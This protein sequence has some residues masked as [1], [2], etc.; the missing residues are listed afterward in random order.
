MGIFAVNFRIPTT[1]FIRF[2]ASVIA[3][4]V[5]FSCSSPST[6]TPPKEASTAAESPVKALPP[7]LSKALE[8]HGGI[9]NWQGMQTLTY[10]IVKEAGNERHVIDLKTRR[11]HL[12][13]EDW[14]L[15]FDGTDV[16]VMP[17]SAA[18]GSGN[19]R[20]YHNLVFYFFALPYLAADPGVNYED[21]GPAT[22]NGNTYDR[23]L[24]TF[25]SG[26]GDAPDDK[27]ILYF[28]DQGIME[29]INYSVTY[30]DKNRADRFNAI[31]YR[32]WKPVNGLLLPET[33]VGYRWQ[34]DSLGE[35][36]YVRRFANISLS[37]QA[38]DPTLFAKP[39]G[40]YVSP[41]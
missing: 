33:M 19:A 15:G 20:F 3:A 16:W 21:L 23:V 36:R 28:N 5:L 14:K 10:D 30:F 13:T 34:G 39:D 1:M 2:I 22:V 27:Y 26:V 4:V 38:S 18:F 9:D 24:M 31:A 40:A 32:D 7:V 11:V 6:S 17:D 41:L 37:A 25:D 8:A 12:S 29:L 35:E